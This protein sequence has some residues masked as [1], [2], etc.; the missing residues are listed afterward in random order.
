MLGINGDDDEHPARRNAD[1]CHSP[2]RGMFVSS[3]WNVEVWCVRYKERREGR[4]P[5]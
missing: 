4:K 1:G 3:L 2:M 5:T